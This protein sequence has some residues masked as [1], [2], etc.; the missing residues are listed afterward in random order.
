MNLV[1]SFVHGFGEGERFMAG[2]GPGEAA[3]VKN[4]C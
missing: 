3:F 4:E 1:G 2:V